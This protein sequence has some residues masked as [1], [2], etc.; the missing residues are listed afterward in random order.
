MEDSNLHFIVI[1]QYNRCL[2]EKCRIL[3]RC[4]NMLF[5]LNNPVVEIISISHLSWKKQKAAV[6]PRDYCSLAFRIKGDGEIKYN[7]KKIHFT[8]ND[9]LYFPQNIGYTA[10][11]SDTEI[12]VIHFKTAVSDSLVE[13]FSLDNT[14]KTYKSFLEALHIWQ[15]KEVGYEMFAISVLYKILGTLYTEKQKQT[16]PK[17]FIDALSIINSEFKNSTLSISNVCR[18]ANISEAY[19]R[20][21][22]SEHYNK[23]PNTYVTQLRIENAQNLISN[24]MSIKDA[25]FI[26]G[27]NDPKYFS[28][29]VKKHLH[30]T[31]RELKSYGK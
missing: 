16:I 22:F 15:S 31:P 13:V 23:T 8:A 9:V 29:V 27:F 6:L 14:E 20:R 18:E 2:P 25:S 12:I 11:Y 7:G 3:T 19:F 24:G 4:T 17:S 21:L 1:K 28:R 5:D 26:S 10:N 30:C